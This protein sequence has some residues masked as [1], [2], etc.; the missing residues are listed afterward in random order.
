VIYGSVLIAFMW[1]LPEGAAGLPRRLR[2][3]AA[4]RRHRGEEPEA[5]RESRWTRREEVA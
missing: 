3:L 4:R 1:V 2:A 5:A